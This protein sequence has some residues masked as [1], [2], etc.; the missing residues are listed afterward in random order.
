[1]DRAGAVEQRVHGAGAAVDRLDGGG[2]PH[3]EAKGRDGRPLG[4]E[5]RQRILVDVGGKHRGARIRES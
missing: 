2:V 3:V 4:R 1:M 5:R